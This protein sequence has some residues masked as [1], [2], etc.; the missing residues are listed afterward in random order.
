M[1]NTIRHQTK[2]FFL[3]PTT[4]NTNL[5]YHFIIT[6]DNLQPPYLTP[7]NNQKKKKKKKTKNKKT[8]TKK[9][10]IKTKK[11]KKTHPPPPQKK[12]K[13]KNV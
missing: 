9:Y 13:K 3:K 1:L 5:T 10:P 4:I 7:Q 11:K 12:K 8:K 2:T 6:K